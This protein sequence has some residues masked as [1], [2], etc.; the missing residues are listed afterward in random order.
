MNVTTRTRLRQILCKPGNHRVPEACIVDLNVMRPICFACR[1]IE[2]ARRLDVAPS[3]TR[4][5]ALPAQ[6]FRMLLR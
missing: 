2:R 6:R 1:I 3:N 5:P 4:E